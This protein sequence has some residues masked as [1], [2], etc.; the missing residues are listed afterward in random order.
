MAHL[1]EIDKVPVLE[2][3]DDNCLMEHFRKLK[4]KVEILFKGPLNNANDS[5]K[6]NYIIYWSVEVGM[7]FS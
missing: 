3:T 4:K 5:V 1:A 2:W 6:C 7:E